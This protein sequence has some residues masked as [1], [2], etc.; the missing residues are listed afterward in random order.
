MTA[1]HDPVSDS[2]GNI[3]SSGKITKFDPTNNQWTEF[4]PPT[5]PANVRRN[6]AIGKITRREA[7]E[8]T[9]RREL[10][11]RRHARQ[12]WHGANRVDMWQA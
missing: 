8:I 7:F 2:K 3:W 9:R 1:P 11:E 10:S 4:T 6:V 12:G 5:Y